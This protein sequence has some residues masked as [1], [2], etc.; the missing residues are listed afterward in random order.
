MDEKKTSIIDRINSEDAKIS[1]A[2]VESILSLISGIAI[3]IFL[4][5]GLI[6]GA[7]VTG[8][9]GTLLSFHAKKVTRN[10]HKKVKR[11]AIAGFIFSIIGLSIIVILFIK[12]V[13]FP[14]EGVLVEAPYSIQEIIT[15]D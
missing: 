10:A 9:A 4:I 14:G 13:F 8:I 1:R 5:L 3:Y 11:I 6:Y 2:N 12:L 7:M 15:N